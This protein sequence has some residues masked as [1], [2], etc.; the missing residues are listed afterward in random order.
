MSLITNALSSRKA[1]IMVASIVAPNLIAS[2][3]SAPANNTATTHY[4]SCGLSAASFLPPSAF[5]EFFQ[6]VSETSG[7][8]PWHGLRH[9]GVTVPLWVTSFQNSRITG[10]MN[11]KALRQPFIQQEDRQKARVAHI[12]T[13]WPLSPLDGLIVQRTPGLLE[14][15][16]THTAFSTAAGPYSLSSQVLRSRGGLGGFRTLVETHPKLQVGRV[17]YDFLGIP[18]ATTEER[19]VLIGVAYGPVLAQFSFQGGRGMSSA[20]VAPLLVRATNRLGQACKGMR[21]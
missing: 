9:R 11:R 8:P 14:V 5:G 3:G 18:P 16:Q 21:D 6:D 15:F 10:A 12:P 1:A 2:C 4:L 17:M 7:I 20:A 13:P 19:I